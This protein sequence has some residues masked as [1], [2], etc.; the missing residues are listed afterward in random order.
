MLGKLYCRIRGHDDI[1][2]AR[3]V[4]LFVNDVA[5]PGVE[6]EDFCPTCGRYDVR[7]V[8]V[9]DPHQIEYR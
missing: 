3:E 7:Y 5:V 6:I 4:D 2:V 8:I 9:N 1:T